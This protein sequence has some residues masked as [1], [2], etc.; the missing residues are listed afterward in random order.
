L[1]G[2]KGK[3]SGEY[4]VSPGGRAT[5]FEKKGEGNYFV[6][7][8]S[9]ESRKKVAN[10]MYD[11]SGER[12]MMSEKQKTCPERSRRKKNALADGE[13]A[14]KGVAGALLCAQNEK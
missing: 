1:R 6:A 13:M 11:N 9:Q 3:E 14:A 10:A 5:P 2:E 12:R 7:E 4:P 8:M